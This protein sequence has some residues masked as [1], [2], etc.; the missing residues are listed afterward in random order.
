MKFKLFQI[1][2]LNLLIKL[3]FLNGIMGREDPVEFYIG[4]YKKFYK[5]VLYYI[6][7]FIFN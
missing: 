3:K 6:Y 2:N 4:F 1:K 5:Y 7:K